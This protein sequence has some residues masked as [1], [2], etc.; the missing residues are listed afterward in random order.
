[1]ASINDSEETNLR[2]ALVANLFPDLGVLVTE[3]GSLGAVDDAHHIR[4]EVEH[5]R[6]G[7]FGFASHSC[8]GDAESLNLR[9]EF[10]P[11]RVRRVREERDQHRAIESVDVSIDPR[12]EEKGGETNL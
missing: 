8:F 6:S 4:L 3:G 12:V 2:V 5:R 7:I 11:V 1:M 10:V 9:S